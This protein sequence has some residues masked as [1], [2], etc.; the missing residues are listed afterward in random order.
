MKKVFFF[1]SILLVLFHV[2]V[3]YAGNEP[4]WYRLSMIASSF[5]GPSGLF[6]I[7]SDRTIPKG[8]S[9]MGIH[10]YT[11]K[12]TLGLPYETEVGMMFA[13]DTTDDIDEDS[14]KKVAFNA[15]WNI[16]KQEDYPAG[17]SVGVSNREVYTV[18]SK[19]FPEFFH[20]ALHPGLKYTRDEKLKGFI[21]ITKMNWR[22]LFVSDYNGDSYTFGL[23]SLI[24]DSVKFDFFLRGLE[25]FKDFSFDN[26]IF[27]VSFTE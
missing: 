15:K 24:A 3:S 14:L 27:G 10:K 21:G 2:R 6:T 17:V 23:R 1:F 5:D 13:A 25:D 20:F 16:L 22:V 11:F 26:V 7:P 4:E 19:Y 8:N 12:Y 18:C 9:S